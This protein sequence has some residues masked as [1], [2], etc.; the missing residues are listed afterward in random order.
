MEFIFKGFVFAPYQG[1]ER[2]SRSMFRKL[3]TPQD[4]ETNADS[5]NG[6]MGDQHSR[7]AFEQ[8]HRAGGAGHMSLRLADKVRPCRGGDAARAMVKTQ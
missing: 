8:K 6:L 2:N 5:S 4:K 7:L 1:M 3:A